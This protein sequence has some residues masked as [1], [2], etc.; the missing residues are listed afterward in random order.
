MNLLHN[1]NSLIILMWFRV[2]MLLNL[3]GME[4][5]VYVRGALWLPLN[6]LPIPS[7]SWPKIASFSLVLFRVLIGS[8]R[9]TSA[10]Q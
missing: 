6:Q 2:L 1:Y 10:S 3:T 4:S 7:I 8:S 5:G 9:A